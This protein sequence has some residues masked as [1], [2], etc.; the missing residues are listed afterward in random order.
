MNNN[1]G[2]RLESRARNWKAL[3]H[4]LRDEVIDACH[5]AGGSWK[6]TAIAVYVSV[7]L[8]GRRHDRSL[9]ELQAWL[10]ANGIAYDI[11]LSDAPAH[12]LC[13]D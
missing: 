8:I 4:E 10:Q 2:L 7:R 1:T 9:T 5:R 11:C 12:R 13:V 6:P 3:S